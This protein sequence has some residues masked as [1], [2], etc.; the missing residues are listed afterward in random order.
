MQRGGPQA[1]RELWRAGF[2]VAL[3]GRIAAFFTPLAPKQ[4]GVTAVL[5]LASVLVVAIGFLGA[6]VFT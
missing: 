1:S 5:T 3:G 4:R 6:S 2:P